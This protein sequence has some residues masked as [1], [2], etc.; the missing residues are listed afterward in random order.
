MLLTERQPPLRSGMGMP[1]SQVA[2][3]D[4]RIAFAT[5]WS[6]RFDLPCDD[7]LEFLCNE[8][9]LILVKANKTWEEALEHCRTLDTDPNSSDTYFNHLYD[10]LHLHSGE[11]DLAKT[12]PLRPK[13]CG[14]V[15]VSW[16]DTCG[17]GQWK[18]SAGSTAGLPPPLW[19]ELS[20]N[21]EDGGAFATR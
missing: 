20:D 18:P 3:P 4:L 1:M 2:F 16:Q 6:Y 12:A 11:A 21:V 5:G 7:H 9:G 17:V 14:P 8:D 13:R 19:E 15:Y 10:L